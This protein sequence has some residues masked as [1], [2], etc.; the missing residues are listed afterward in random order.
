[1]NWKRE[2]EI[3]SAA[4]T[5]TPRQGRRPDIDAAFATQRTLTCCYSCESSLPLLTAKVDR[6]QWH[7]GHGAEG[8]ES[9]QL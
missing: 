2:V 6:R 1:M 7:G 4:P 9:L 3:V 5:M 8:T